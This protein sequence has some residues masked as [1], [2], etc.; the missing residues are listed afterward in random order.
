[1]L[2]VSGFDL[3]PTAPEDSAEQ[4]QLLVA[5]PVWLVDRRHR[6]YRFHLYVVLCDE[7]ASHRVLVRLVDAEGTESWCH[8][9]EKEFASRGPAL[10]SSCLLTSLEA[11]CEHEGHHWLELHL[12]GHARGRLPINV[13]FG[14]EDERIVQTATYAYDGTSGQLLAQSYS[15]PMG[16][17]ERNAEGGAS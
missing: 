6:T 2:V 13:V 7:P 11:H 15:A 3:S 16:L 12:N 4:L 8:E 5:P 17:P 10:G 9:T 14:P 1:L